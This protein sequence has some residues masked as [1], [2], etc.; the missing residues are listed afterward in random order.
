MP[1][2]SIQILILG[3]SLITKC[4]MI[5]EEPVNRYQHSPESIIIRV[6][7][8][9]NSLLNFFQH[10]KEINILLIKYI[11]NFPHIG[12]LII[13][14]SIISKKKVPAIWSMPWILSITK[15]YK[16]RQMLSFMLAKNTASPTLRR[17]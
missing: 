14:W 4:W 1:K 8:I 5:M 7:P 13:I 11:S 2:I 15:G 9:K 17:K 10:L 6:D 3:N 12:Y 16:Y